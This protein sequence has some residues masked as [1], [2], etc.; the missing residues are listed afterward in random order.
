MAARIFIT[1]YAVRQPTETALQI[2]SRPPSGRKI[3]TQIS[4]RVLL[5]FYLFESA[6]ILSVVIVS[7]TTK[8]KTFRNRVIASE[9]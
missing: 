6:L 4:G 8:P 5:Y 7:S 3:E 9:N 1:S 2:L